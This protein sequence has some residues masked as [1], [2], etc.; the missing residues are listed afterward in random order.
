MSLA[1][2]ACKVREIIMWFAKKFTEW[3]NDNVK[4]SQFTC[5]SPILGNDA[6]K[7]DKKKKKNKY[8]VQTCRFLKLTGNVSSQC[9]DNV[10]HILAND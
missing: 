9:P 3:G 10:I 6:K 5:L 8:D 1:S 7:S 4:P 2:V